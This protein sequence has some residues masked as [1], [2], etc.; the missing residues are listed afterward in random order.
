M[1]HQNKKMAEAAVL[2]RQLL[3]KKPTNLFYKSLMLFY[4]Q[5]GHLTPRQIQAISENWTRD[6]LPKRFSRFT[7]G[8]FSKARL[9]ELAKWK[10]K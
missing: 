10:S 2:L 9:D 5:H 3:D 7:K 6:I 8:G 1:K 4:E